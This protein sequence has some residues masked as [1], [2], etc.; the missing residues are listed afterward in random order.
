M[1]SS[2]NKQGIVVPF[3]PLLGVLLLNVLLFFSLFGEWKILW[4]GEVGFSYDVNQG[5]HVN[6]KENPPGHFG[7]NY[8]FGWNQAWMDVDGQALDAEFQPQTHKNKKGEEEKGK[9][10]EEMEWNTHEGV[11]MSVS[12]RVWGQVQDPWLF[13]QHFYLL[14]HDYDSVDIDEHVYEAL[15]QAGKMASRY[16][17]EYAA[18]KSAEE[19]RA[20]PE[21]LRIHIMTAAAKYMH[22]LGFEVTKLEFIG[23][24]VFMDGDAIQEARSQITKV[25]TEAQS[26][27]QKIANRQIQLGLAQSAAKVVADNKV[28]LAKRKASRVMAETAGLI[29]Q[30]G[31]SVEQIGENATMHILMAE[32]YGDLMKQGVLPLV[33]V[34]EKSIFAAPFYSVND[35]VAAHVTPTP[36]VEKPKVLIVPSN[37]VPPPPAAEKPAPP[38]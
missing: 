3:F 36:T 16:A 8:A 9:Y 20:N 34:D 15:R 14:E 7:L 31:P 18:A 6:P 28:A 17:C 12:Y 10:N 21:G 23:N 27:E 30:L 2:D 35:K 33:V 22:E 13:Y 19:I 29:S 25:T 38:Q 37:V 4:R 32:Q 26:V 11:V 24:F 1:S 5:E